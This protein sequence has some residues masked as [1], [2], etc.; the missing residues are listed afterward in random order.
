[1]GFRRIFFPAQIIGANLLHVRMHFRIVRVRHWQ[2]D[3]SQSL[4][5][6]EP[7]RIGILQAVAVRAVG[8]LHGMAIQGISRPDIRLVIGG[9]V[10][11]N[12]AVGRQAEPPKRLSLRPRLRRFSGA[13]C[14]ACELRIRDARA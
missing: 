10:A 11:M 3:P 5:I 4:D 13:R 8:R 12:S 6:P 9:S 14:V 1:M 2:K 7:A